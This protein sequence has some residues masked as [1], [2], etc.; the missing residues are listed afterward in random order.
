MLRSIHPNKLPLLTC[1]ETFTARLLGCAKS[2]VREKEKEGLL[3]HVPFWRD[4]GRRTQRSPFFPD[5]W[6]HYD[7]RHYH[8]DDVLA[9]MPAESEMTKYLKQLKRRNRSLLAGQVGLG[10]ASPYLLVKVSLNGHVSSASRPVK[11]PR[12]ALPANAPSVRG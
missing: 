12:K 7:V 1:S 6:E 2:D 11:R 9:L 3:K 5:Y 10:S 8:L 4:H